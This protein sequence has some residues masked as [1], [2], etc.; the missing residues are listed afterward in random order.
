MATLGQDQPR[1]SH[2]PLH[3]LCMISR[4]ICA[5]PDCKGGRWDQELTTGDMVKTS[6]RGAVCLPW[7]TREDPREPWG[8]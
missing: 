1:K 3:A 7:D 5:R 6:S 8:L 2:H 4:A